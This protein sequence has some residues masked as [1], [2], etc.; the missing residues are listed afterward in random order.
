MKYTQVSS[1]PYTWK[2]SW[3]FNFHWLHST[4]KIKRTKIKATRTIGS[5]KNS[6]AVPLHDSLSLEIPYST[7]ISRGFNFVNFANLKSFAKLFHWKIWHFE[8]ESHWAA[9]S[10][11][12]F[13]EMK[14]PSYLWK[15]CPAKYKCYTVEYKLVKR[16]QQMAFYC[17]I[18]FH[19]HS[20][21]IMS[22]PW[23]W[24]AY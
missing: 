16:W 20:V 23:L 6:T 2:F 14:K 10:W 11:N 18:L 5:T 24:D 19:C 21:L 7:Y 8:V 15:F 9:H 4:V 12:Y 17:P 3:E 22:I 13:N 1:I